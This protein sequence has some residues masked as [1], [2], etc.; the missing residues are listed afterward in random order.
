MILLCMREDAR[1]YDLDDCEAAMREAA[2]GIR[3]VG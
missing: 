3:P 1:Y 2:D